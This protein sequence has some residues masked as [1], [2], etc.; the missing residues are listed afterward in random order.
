MPY[1]YF[2]LA[3]SRQQCETSVI[4][5]LVSQQF[6]YGF[7]RRYMGSGKLIQRGFCR[8]TWDFVGVQRMIYNAA[9]V[10]Y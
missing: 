7:H 8:G 3:S 2:L 5:G 1:T 6:I 10:I 9:Y 4:Y